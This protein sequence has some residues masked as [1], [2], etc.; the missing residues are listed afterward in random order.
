MNNLIK[1]NFTQIPNQLI[2]DQHL[3]RDSRFLFVYLCSKPDTWK[4]YVKTI[5]KELNCSK[6]TRI[7]YMNELIKAG[8]I[9]VAQKQ[10]NA[11]KFGA[12][13]IVLNPYP[14]FYATVK[15]ELQPQ[16]NSSAAVKDGGGK[17]SLHINTIEKEILT[18]KEE[19]EK[20]AN[21]KSFA[22]TLFPA[23]PLKDLLEEKEK[24][25]PPPAPPA[26]KKEKEY[27]SEVKRC[28]KKCIVLFD[29]H[30]RPQNKAQQNNWLDT[31]DK[32]HNLDGI[33]FENIIEITTKA[34]ADIN[35]WAKNF[36]SI[37]KLRKTNKEGIKYIIVF[38]EQFKTRTPVVNLEAA[39]QADKEMLEYLK[40]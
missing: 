35:F 18:T 8:W 4:Y 1:K 5:E 11:G 33:P 7:K 31:I 13:E 15:N 23:E 28:F 10:D 19:E 17:T 32:L 3:S 12:N 37:V 9:T 24:T 22:A 6:D 16:P 38:S 26:G 14:N 21:E 27:S 30:L 25:I 40:M 39:Q 36:L 2:N 20:A 34:R 29:E